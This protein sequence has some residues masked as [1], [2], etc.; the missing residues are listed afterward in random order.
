MQGDGGNG[1]KEIQTTEQHQQQQQQINQ[2]H[3]HQQHQQNRLQSPTMSQRRYI[4]KTTTINI[5]PTMSPC[6]CGTKSTMNTTTEARLPS[7]S[8]YDPAITPQIVLML[9]GLP[10]SGKSTFAT[11][12]MNEQGS[13]SSSSSVSTSSSSSHYH[14]VHIN[15][16]TL[17]TRQE[18]E[19][20]CR[21]ALQN[22]HSPIIDRCNFNVQQRKYFLDIVHHDIS[23][24]LHNKKKKI[25]VHCIVF[26]FHAQICIQRIQQRQNHPTLSA[27]DASRVVGYMK[28]SYQPPIMG[29]ECGIDRRWTI[30]NQQDCDNLI[31]YLLNAASSTDE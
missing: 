24:L 15:Q 29:N 9:V 20:Y 11:K 31:T 17:G 16:D 6:S 7:L 14:F 30:Q 3:Q 10:G 23:L 21:I 8:Y 4:T 22:G 12:L 26:D 2:Q 25:P 13:S 1:T 28:N 27:Q 18:C 19:H 5:I